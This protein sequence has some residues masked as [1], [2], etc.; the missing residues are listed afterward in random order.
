MVVVV[1]V[2]VVVGC[3]QWGDHAYQSKREGCGLGILEARTQLEIS[4]VR[5]GSDK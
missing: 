5:R 1:V 3:S 2:G 4:G